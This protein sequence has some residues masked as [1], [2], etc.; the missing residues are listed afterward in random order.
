[1]QGAKLRQLDD[2]AVEVETGREGHAFYSRT[3]IGPE[4]EITG[5]L[6][7]VR[8]SNDAFQGG[9]MIGLPDSFNSNWYSFRLKRNA[10]EGQ[11]VSVAHGWTSHQIWKPV[12][13]DDKRNTFKFRLKDGK[14]DAWINDAQVIRGAVLDKNMHLAGDSLVG[15]G[16]YHDTNDTVVRYRNVKN[17]APVGRSLARLPR[18]GIA[19]RC[20]K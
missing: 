11:G 8:S 14:V 18:F 3:R 20:A 16:A 12:N 2:G 4:F 17:P 15:F 10:T 5:E 6:E 13:L 19:S 1:M 7:I 9:L